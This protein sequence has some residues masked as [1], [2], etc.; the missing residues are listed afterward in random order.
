MSNYIDG[1]VHPIPN[2]RL[3][4]YKEVATQIAEIWKEYGALEYNEYIC[5]DPELMGTRTF[6]QAAEAKEGEVTLFGWVVFDS[7]E[8]RDLANKKVP[9]DPR[10]NELMKP[11]INPANPVFDPSRM[12][13]GG[14]EA[15]VNRKG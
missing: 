8:S 7:K 15:L 14:F 1:F 10:M 5:E 2:D 13:Y 9:L 3:E 11:L 12:I 6:P 4:T